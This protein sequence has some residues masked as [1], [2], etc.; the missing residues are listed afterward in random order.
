MY[1]DASSG[2][3]DIHFEHCSIVH[4]SAYSLNTWGHLTV[5]AGGVV[6]ASTST[7]GI[8]DSDGFV[9]SASATGGDFV[10][11]FGHCSI[12]DSS[13]L[14]DFTGARGGV[15]ALTGDGSIGVRLQN[16]TLINSTVYSLNSS[17]AIYGGVVY[18][19]G[20]SISV[21]LEHCKIVNSA[22]YLLGTKLTKKALSSQA[23][24]GVVYVRGAT[25]TCTDCTIHGSSASDFGGFACLQSGRLQLAHT[26]VS[27]C[28]ANTGGGIYIVTGAVVLGNGTR[29]YAN[30]ARVRGSSF[31]IQSGTASYELP[32]PAAHWLPNSVC[33]AY[34]ED[35]PIFNGRLD[36]QLL[37]GCS[38]DDSR[39]EF[40]PDCRGYTYVPDPRCMAVF[41][42]CRWRADVDASAT[43]PV[44]NGADATPP[45]MGSWQ[46]TRRLNHT[47]PCNWIDDPT[48]L[49]RRIYRLVPGAEEQDFPYACAPGG[50]PCLGLHPHGD[51]VALSLQ[52]PST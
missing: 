23:S 20:D 42:A 10:V 32:A 31:F 24:G 28:L 47:Q 8:V 7:S 52:H 30:T 43:P 49:G 11:L 44:V 39:P 37:P 3:V 6:Y 22:A 40:K 34:R 19:G 25:L 13:A 26:E 51:R 41:D 33:E 15:L 16:C 38:D 45:F 9:V 35:C 29:L 2:T 4:S 50:S 1:A 48:L 12:A 36:G 14:S 21:R 46:C 27:G 18:A 17:I 5:A